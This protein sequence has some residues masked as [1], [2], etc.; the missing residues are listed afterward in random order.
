VPFWQTPAVA[1]EWVGPVATAAVGIVGIAATV[2]TQREGHRATADLAN[3]ARVQDLRRLAYE[4]IIK[5]AIETTEFVSYADVIW[6]R[7]AEPPDVDYKNFDA[8]MLLDLY[9][10]EDVYRR[11]H[12]WSDA[13]S[14]ARSVLD[15]V[16]ENESWLDA[17]DELQNRFVAA[18]KSMENK[19]AQLIQAARSEL[20]PGEA[21]A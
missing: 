6:V 2:C 11:Y 8:W 15:E 21:K 1:W 12:E 13:T 4:R 14:E 17:D 10:S 9:A 7:D 18:S 19:L 3:S 20:L 5:T 16:P